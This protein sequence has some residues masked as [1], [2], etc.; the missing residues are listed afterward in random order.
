[1]TDYTFHLTS[2][3]FDVMAAHLAGG[4]I[5]PPGKCQVAR[6]ASPPMLVFHNIRLWTEYWASAN[7]SESERVSVAATEHL[8]HAG[9]YLVYSSSTQLSLVRRRYKLLYYF[10]SCIR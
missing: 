10:S 2:F 7:I 5:G 9:L 6:R 1:V 4:P 3:T 8:Q